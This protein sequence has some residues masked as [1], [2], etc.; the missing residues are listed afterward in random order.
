MFRSCISAS[1]SKGTPRTQ[2]L[3]CTPCSLCSVTYGVSDAGFDMTCISI[4]LCTGDAR[5]T[6]P[7]YFRRRL[8][9]RKAAEP[10]RFKLDLNDV[11]TK[12]NART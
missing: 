6:K 10:D 8:G 12:L 11:Q 7:L 9:K 1:A 2:A 5:A 3:I 4:P